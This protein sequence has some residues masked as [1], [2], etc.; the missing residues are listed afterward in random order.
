MSKFFDW[1]E[2]HFVPI[3]AKIGSNRYLI[4]IRDAFIAMMP[5]IIAG[6]VAVLLN[7]FVRD[8]PASTGWFANLPTAMAWL[9]TINGNVWWGSTAMLALL[10]VVTL[11]YNLAKNWDCDPLCGAI[12]ALAGY[13]AAN[14]Q[15]VDGWGFIHWSFTNSNAL[16]SAIILTTISSFIFI[17]LSKSKFTINMPEGVPPAVTASFKAM[18]PGVVSVFAMAT[19][20]YVFNI[21]TG[22]DI[23]TVIY[24]MVQAPM[25]EATQSYGLVLLF[26]LL[27]QLLWFFGLHGTNVLAVVFDGVYASAGIANQ[28]AAGL[29]LEMP[30]MWTKTSFEIFGWMGGAGCTFALV[31]AILLFSKKEGPKAVAKIAAPMGAFN[32]NE[33][34]TF[35]VPLVLNPIYFFPFLLVSPL[36]IT[37]GY[38]CTAIGMVPAA[39]VVLPWIT[40]PVIGAI[41]A[42]NWVGGLVALFNL[43]LAIAI[44]SIFVIIGNKVEDAE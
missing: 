26:S 2:K 18:I 14:P 10:L 15:G 21:T 30:Y 13:I 20:Y 7:V 36:L 34:V 31:I 29:G 8:I 23:N 25:M 39:S 44:W 27:V 3:A 1:M 28:T 11:G 24:A 38:V 37:I 6:T 17:G 22:S 9:I 43:A 42:T 16:F 5:V 41:L 32:I 12:V 19:I 35:G 40:P 4:A 33:P